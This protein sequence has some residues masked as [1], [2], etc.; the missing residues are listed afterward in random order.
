MQ[1][2]PTRGNAANWSPRLFLRTN[3]FNCPLSLEPLP[4]SNPKR[5][6]GLLAEACEMLQI[7]P[8]LQVIS[9]IIFGLTSAY[10]ARRRGKNPYLWF[11]LGVLFGCFGVAAIV[12][13]E[14]KPPKPASIPAEPYI[15]GPQEHFWYYLDNARNQTGPMS[16][17]AIND[18]WKKGKISPATFVWHRDLPD[19]KPL[20][21][22]IKWKK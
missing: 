5:I 6:I 9:S 12:F 22:L 18:F 13:G 2:T 20:Q 10:L 7:D 3:M 4:Q 17:Q 16:F 15:E 8:K 11:F 19:W 21:D 14:K 1:A